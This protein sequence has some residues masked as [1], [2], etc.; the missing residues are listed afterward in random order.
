MSWSRGMENTNWSKQSSDKPLFPDLLW[1]RPE[2]KAQAGKLLVIGGNLHGFAATMSAYNAAIA[3]GIGPARVVLPQA[4]QKIVGTSFEGAIFAPA[5]PSGSLARQALDTL[6]E[7]AKWADGVLLAGDFG[8]N[9]ETAIL[10]G[11]FLEKYDGPVAVAQDG[12]D[13]FLAANSP[14]LNRQNTLS[15]I[16]LGTLQKLAKNNGSSVA[17][18]HNMT[19]HELVTFLQQWPTAG[20]YFITQHQEQYVVA[21]DGKVSTTPA[22]ENKNWQIEMAAYASV[23]LIQNPSKPFEALTTAVYE[24]SK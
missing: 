2:N 10:L 3:A 11:S 1:S 15:I 13:Y 21:A 4:L 12:L 22:Q 19:L 24:Y 7:N 20:K 23:W 14:L 16:S 5:T 18:R 17:I 9:S 8:R 6:L